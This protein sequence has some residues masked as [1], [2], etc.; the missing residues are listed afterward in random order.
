MDPKK[1]KKV[2]E[3]A[4]LPDILSLLK[5]LSDFQES[6]RE[7][8]EKQPL[9]EVKEKI[10]SMDNGLNS[11]AEELIGIA[12]NYFKGNAAVQEQIQE[13]DVTPNTSPVMM[14]SPYLN[15]SK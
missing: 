5:E 9:T 3:R 1:E 11:M 10:K 12:T 4:G 15:F 7:C 14:T 2:N 8:A 13:Q 6:V